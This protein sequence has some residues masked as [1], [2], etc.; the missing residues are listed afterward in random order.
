VCAAHALQRVGCLL[1]VQAGTQQWLLQCDS[2]S[3]RLVPSAC[4]SKR[5]ARQL[6]TQFTALAPTASQDT[7]SLTGHTRQ[8]HTASP[9]WW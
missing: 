4:S 8:P 7:N 9:V 3:S 5:D 6:A 2:G 1:Q